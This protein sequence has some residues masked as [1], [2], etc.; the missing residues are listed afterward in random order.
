MWYIP[1]YTYVLFILLYCC[2]LCV[3]V[4]FYGLVRIIRRTGTTS[5][6]RPLDT[7]CRKCAK[8]EAAKS[9]R[10]EMLLGSQGL[11]FRV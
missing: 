4:D 9:H 5:R 2:V 6:G 7:C 3:Y 11:G 1:L 10:V 8:A